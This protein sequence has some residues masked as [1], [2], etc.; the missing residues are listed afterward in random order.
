MIDIRFCAESFLKCVRPDQV[1]SKETV[2]GIERY[3]I[4]RVKNK[5]R[6]KEA[7]KQKKEKW[8][9]C[10]FAVLSTEDPK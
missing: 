6:K 5:E 9:I 10:L 8:E 7:N 1:E 4:D 2:K 3:I